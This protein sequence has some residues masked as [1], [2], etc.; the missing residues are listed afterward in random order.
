MNLQHLL[1]ECARGKEPARKQLFDAVADSLFT[2][3]SRYVKN[4]ADAEEVML[5]GFRNLFAHISKFRYETD[6]GFYAWARKIMVNQCLMFLRR[7]NAF[8]VSIETYAQEVQIPEDALNN[9]SAKE[10]YQAI[11]QLPAGYR[12]VFNL[13]EIEGYSH[14]EIAAML[15]ISEGTSK[16]QLSKAKNWLQHQLKKNEPHEQR[17]IQ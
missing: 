12:T 11:L 9:L 4:A 6:A 5:D 13:F 2:L 10:I 3:C 7:E 8:S 15:N 14:K 17:K 1:K 16:S